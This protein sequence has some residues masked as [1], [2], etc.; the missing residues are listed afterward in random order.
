MQGQEMH[1]T[2]LNCGNARVE[3]FF[4]S[5]F[6]GKFANSS[7]LSLDL[8]LELIIF[9]RPVPIMFCVKFHRHKKVT[10]FML[11]SKHPLNM[12]KN[13]TRDIQQLRGP[14]LPDFDHPFPLSW[15]LWTFYITIPI[16]WPSVEFLLITYLLLPTSTCLLRYWMPHY[17]SIDYLKR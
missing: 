1:E 12:L 17:I 15:Q 16:T 6:Y 7:H 9:V 3:S 5:R 14:D 4:P 10:P 11:S 13:A 8:S 2:W